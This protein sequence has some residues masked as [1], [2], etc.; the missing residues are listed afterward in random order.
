MGNYMVLPKKFAVSSNLRHCIGMSWKRKVAISCLWFL[1]LAPTSE[2]L[3]TGAKDE[4]LKPEELVAKHLE[5]IGPAEKRKAITSRAT[6][7]TAQVVFRVGGNG[8]LN[9]KGNLLSDGNSVRLGFN[10]SAVDYPGE[11]VA[12]DGSKVTAGQMSPGNYPPFSDFIYQNDVL[13]KEGLLFG[14]LSTGWT[15]LNVSSKQ[16]KLESN[17]LKKI[18]GRELYELKYLSRNTKANIQAWLYFEPETF[19]HVRSQ[20]RLELPARMARITDS[21]EM[22]RYQILEQFDQFKEVDGLT[23][24]YSYKLDFTIDS[25]RGGMLT[26]WTHVIDRIMHNQS[27]ERQLFTVQ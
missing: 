26:S 18:E 3:A 8:N 1:L 2:P 17:G 5:S 25:P 15:L 22:V 20:F 24:P 27:F 23:L 10:F 9:G 11:Q 19:H 21:A 13:L 4:K 16:P 7:G 6:V 14:A 12:F